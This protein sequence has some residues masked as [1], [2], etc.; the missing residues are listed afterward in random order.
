M[1]K[2]ILVVILLVTGGLFAQAP[3]PKIT[4]PA[5]PLPQHQAENKASLEAQLTAYKAQMR[6][7][8]KVAKFQTKLAEEQLKLQQVQKKGQRKIAVARAK[9]E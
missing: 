1:R 2:F 5:E 9:A 8:L 4:P 7:S 6:E 3:A